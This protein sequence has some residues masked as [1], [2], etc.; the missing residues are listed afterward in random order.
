MFSIASFVLDCNTIEHSKTRQEIDG[1]THL[2]LI[3]RPNIDKFTP[4]Y[5]VHARDRRGRRDLI[6]RVAIEVFFSSTCGVVAIP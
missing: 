2:V 6:S 4:L 5:I 3:T 1:F